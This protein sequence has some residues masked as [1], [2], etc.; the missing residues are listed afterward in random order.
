MKVGDNVRRIP[1]TFG[2]ER[3]RH[4]KAVKVPLEGRVV[5]IHPKNRFHV[6]EFPVL[7]GKTVREAFWG[8][9]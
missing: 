2:V 8:V 1:L 3:P 7:R 5:Y 4:G 9:R 6:V